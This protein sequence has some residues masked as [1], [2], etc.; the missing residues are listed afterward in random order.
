V[1]AYLVLCGT[2]ILVSDGGEPTPH[3]TR[4]DL[5]FNEPPELTETDAIFERDG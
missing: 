1:I 4:R 5:A 2:R 3:V